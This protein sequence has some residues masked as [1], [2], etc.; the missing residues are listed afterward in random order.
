VPDP[1][2]DLDSHKDGAVNLAAVPLID[3]D[4]TQPNVFP[5]RLIRPSVNGKAKRPQYLQVYLAKS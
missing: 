2:F 3:M 1:P 4:G 5:R